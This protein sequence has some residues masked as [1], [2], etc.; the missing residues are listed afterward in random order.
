MHVDSESAPRVSSRVG[1]EERA[2]DRLRY[3]VG[4][5]GAGGAWVRNVAARKRNTVDFERSLEELEKLV[6]R[7]EEGE[8]SLEDS[9][10]HYERGIRLGRSCERALDEAEQR[11]Q[12][13]TEKDG[14]SEL[15]L[16]EAHDDDVE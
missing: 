2:L 14:Q 1:S 12:V 7:M 11:I 6:E 8:L 10:A 5:G 16:F 3:V 13:L 9:L 4:G 15:T